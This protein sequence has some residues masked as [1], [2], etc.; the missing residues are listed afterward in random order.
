MSNITILG[1]GITGLSLGS[2]LSDKNHTVTI[3]EKSAFVGGLAKSF[4]YKN[5][6]FDL[7][8]HKLYSQISG[9]TQEFKKV[10]GSGA[11]LKIL[12]KNSIRLQGKYFDFPVKIPQV[13]LGINPIK[14]FKLGVGFG[15][16]ILNSNI[17]KRNNKTYED[18]FIAGFG[19]PAYNMLFKDMAH[20]TWGDPKEL[21]EELARKR[22]P[23]PNIIQLLKSGSGTDSEGREL[24]AKYFYY[25]KK[26]GIGFISN[27][28]ADNISRS[29]GK[30]KTNINLKSISLDKNYVKNISY[31][32]TKMH[33]ENTDFL[34]STIYLKDLLHLF[35][36]KPPQI[37]LDAASRLKYRS[38]I[39]IYLIVNKNRVMKDNWIFFPERKYIFN[40]VSEHNSFNS[41]LVANHKAVITAEITCDFSD[42][43][44]NSSDDYIFRRII[45][46]LENAG[47]LTEKDVKE[48]FIKK[49]DGVYPVY[50]L[51]YKKNLQCT[52]DYLDKIKNLITIGRQ[53][54]YNYNNIDHCIDAS[55][56]AAEYVN[57]ALKK[58]KN[59]S[60]W[61]EIR[62]HFD[63]YRIVD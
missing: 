36:P 27:Q 48:F 45:E 62:K 18:Y 28:Y 8:P 30:I 60:T 61:K 15:W 10:S 42:D 12:K 57:G 37:V 19:K 51:T 21:S 17:R 1:A 44:Y 58:E 53:G 55:I 13:V 23:V 5:N 47:I 39:L 2:Y 11:L 7:G 34:A 43:I 6:Q 3:F 63:S 40:R 24:S 56:K 41:K 25:P 26:I 32:D 46:D 4:N 33:T 20:K 14:S 9:I 22:I 54:L 16:S 29:G 31:S 59:I 52:L 35:N 50:D 49:L 38:L